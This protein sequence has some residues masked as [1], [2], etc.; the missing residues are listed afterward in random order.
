M[1]LMPLMLVLL[2][3]FRP[4]G[5]MGLRE[6]SWLVPANDRKAAV[7]QAPPVGAA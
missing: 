7:P 1:M 3:L 5:I 6:F 2:M 4:R